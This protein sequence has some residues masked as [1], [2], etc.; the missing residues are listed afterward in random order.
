MKKGFLLEKESGESR[1]A[2]DEELK[3]AF[4]E[5]QVK[6]AEGR[7]GIRECE[8][9][10]EAL[11]QSRKKAQLTQ[12]ELESLPP[13]TKAYASLGRC[14]LAQSLTEAVASVGADISSTDARIAAVEKRKDYLHKSIKEQENNLRDMVSQR[15]AQKS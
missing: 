12:T 7:K 5:L 13:E 11:R 15:Q 3:K 2:V 14:F 8:A 6:L 10:G 1:A 4:A 9:E